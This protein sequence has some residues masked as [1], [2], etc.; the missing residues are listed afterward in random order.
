[1]SSKNDAILKL[2]T[3]SFTKVCSCGVAGCID[4]RSWITESDVPFNMHG[5]I[6]LAIANTT[7][8]DMLRL[9]NQRYTVV[10]VIASAFE[11]PVVLQSIRENVASAGPVNCFTGLREPQTPQAPP[12]QAPPAAAESHSS[13]VQDAQM[14]DRLGRCAD[15]LSKAAEAL[16][17]DHSPVIPLG[18][19]TIVYDRRRFLQIFP[20]PETRSWWRHTLLG[21]LTD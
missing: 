11:A 10:T 16:E 4:C 6:M 3:L 7:G 13:P 14:A 2:A 20:V 9:L 5:P 12:A 18:K 21:W 17:K 8:V 15:A 1:M 19:H